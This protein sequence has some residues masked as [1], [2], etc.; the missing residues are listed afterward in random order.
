M[1]DYSHTK[2]STFRNCRCKYKLQYIDKIKVD[3]TKS[4]ESF[5]GSRVHEALEKLY[6]DKMYC[7]DNSLEDILAFYNDSWDSQ[8]DDSITIAKKEY[9]AENYRDQGIKFITD[10]YESHKPFNDMTIIGLET[11]DKLHLPNGDTYSIRIDKFA[12][13]GDEYYVC[14]YK[15]DKRLKTQEA[16]DED[17][18]LAMYSVW[19]KRNYPDAKRVHLL[20]HMLRFNKDVTSERTDEQLDALLKETMNTIH[21]IEL[22]TDW[23]PNVTALCDYCE[24]K[25][26]C[27]EFRH[28]FEIESKTREEL[29]KDTAYNAVNEYVEL[30]KKKSE[31]DKEIKELESRMSEISSELTDYAN[32]KGIST[33]F[34]SDYKISV[35]R[36]D[37]VKLKD[38]RKDELK[39]N[40][41][42]KGLNDLL[43]INTSKLYSEV[44]KGEA[45]P[46]FSEYVDVT[47]SYKVSKSKRKP[48]DKDESENE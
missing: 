47:E 30:D 16:A 27:P 34:G 2:L 37:S 39:I 20:W 26:H 4:I 18:Q 36:S 45:D 5:L 40:I 24:F 32:S 42:D 19:V 17:R 23:C 44:R 3:R 25:R 31:L 8:Y 35:K 43:Q 13:I 1:A 21:D 41:I 38:E 7:K 10:Y 22:C 28:E 12:C 29:N 48:T 6:R 14:D 46:M 9:T 15:T 33:V 11:E